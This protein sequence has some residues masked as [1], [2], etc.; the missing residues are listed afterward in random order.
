MKTIIH[1]GIVYKMVPE[2]R[3]GKCNGCVFDSKPGEYMS[4][5]CGAM[6][7]SCAEH[8]YIYKLKETTMKNSTTIIKEYAIEILENR[9]QNECEIA[10][11]YD[12][13]DAQTHVDEALGCIEDYDL[14]EL[15]TDNLTI[16]DKTLTVYAEQKL[17]DS[18]K[19][20]FTNMKNGNAHNT[21]DITDSV[22]GKAVEILEADLLNDIISEK[23]VELMEF[24]L[25][26]FYE[27]IEN[28][29]AYPITDLVKRAIN[30]VDEDQIR[31]MVKETVSSEVETFINNL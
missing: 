8:K 27:R 31:T 4:A 1:N 24:Y 11:V 30:Q 6:M 25:Q 10:N 15:I 14:E 5:A 23:S 17:T 9:L 29:F 18:V 28:Q 13:N 26:D 2:E 22:R 19:D 16:D 12:S 20:F 21:D 7:G 3:K